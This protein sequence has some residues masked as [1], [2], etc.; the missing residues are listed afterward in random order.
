MCWLQDGHFSKAVL[1]RLVKYRVLCMESDVQILPG[2][3][4]RQHRVFFNSADLETC[5]AAP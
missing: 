4:F 3:T 1:E 2:R 5:P